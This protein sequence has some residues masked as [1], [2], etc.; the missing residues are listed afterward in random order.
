MKGEVYVNQPHYLKDGTGRVDRLLRSLYILKR[1]PQVWY[2]TLFAFLKI[3]GIFLLN[4]DLSVY[5]K[6]RLMMG[7]FVDD[8]RIKDVS[9]SEIEAA[10]TAFQVWFSMSDLGLYKFYL[11]MTVTRDCKKQIF[12]LDQRTYLKKI[13]LNHQTM[14]CKPAPTPIKTQNLKVAFTNHQPEE[15]FRTCYQSAIRLLMYTILRTRPNLVFVV[16]VFSRYFS[17][18]N[19]SHGK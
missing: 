4:A 15:L 3:Y 19:N 8:R 13:L 5:A 17:R 11:G 18:P 16:F 6:P 7:I 9:T 10:K 1:S 14:D 12:Q 2:D